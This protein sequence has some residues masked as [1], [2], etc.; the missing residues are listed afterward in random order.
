MLWASASAAALLRTRRL[1]R[2]RML[3]LYP[4]LL[5]N[6]YFVTLHVGA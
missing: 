5:L 3:V 6:A 4:L 1:E 2:R